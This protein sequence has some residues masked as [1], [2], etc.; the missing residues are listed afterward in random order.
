MRRLD[1]VVVG[2]GPAGATAA[3]RIARLGYEV[4]LFDREVFPRDK[5]CGEFVN[6]SA[7]DFI[8]EVFGLDRDDLIAAGGTRVSHVQFQL[9]NCQ[10]LRIPMVDGNR[11][12]VYGISLRRIVLDS[13]LLGRCREMGMAVHEGHNVR[14]IRRADSAILIK[15]TNGGGEPFECQAKIVLAADGTHSVL[16][17]NEGLTIPNRNLQTIGIAAHFSGVT[18]GA[19]QESCVCMFPSDGDGLMFGLSYQSGGPAALSGSVPSPLARQV[20]AGSE[21]FLRNWIARYPELAR[22]LGTATVECPVLTTSCFGH[23]L[24]RSF[25]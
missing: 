17:R 19:D 20:A 10:P 3:Y 8:D 7:C 18:P 11:R 14:S 15:G 4:A 22:D 12:S 1:V 6:P 16:A 25:G 24:K 13:L 9:P 2:G 23:R 21:R 5:P